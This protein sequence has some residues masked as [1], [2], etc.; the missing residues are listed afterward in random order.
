MSKRLSDSVPGLNAAFTFEL[1]TAGRKMRRLFDGVVRE[2]GLTLSRAR[3]LLL[4]SGHRTWT[5]AELADALD[6]EPPSVVRL[7]DGLERQGMISRSAVEGDRRA[8]HIELT[9][10]ARVQI[11][12]MEEIS[13]TVRSRLLEGI[14]PEDLKIALAVLRQVVSNAEAARSDDAD[15][16]APPAD[17]KDHVR[18]Q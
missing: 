5:Q 1:S 8:K 14:D 13:A 2:H 3:A 12:H 7:L 10:P 9:E 4:L 16:T 17:G 11:G 18:A 6:V 15:L